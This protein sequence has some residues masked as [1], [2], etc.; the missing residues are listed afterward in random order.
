MLL[1]ILHQGRF[2]D[3]EQRTGPYHVVVDGAA[4]VVLVLVLLLLLLFFRRSS[5]IS[6]SSS[7]IVVV[8]DTTSR[9][10]VH[11]LQMCNV[12]ASQKFEK[13]CFIG[14]VQ[15][16]GSK[17][18]SFHLC[19]GWMVCSCVAQY[20]VARLLHG[21]LTPFPGRFLRKRLGFASVVVMVRC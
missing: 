3:S 12:R 20:C 18:Y 13:E 15:M 9:D 21:R 11:P 14:I 1:E 8:V 17:Q 6:I 2:G 16:M 19:A 10:H 7:I 4:V 5:S